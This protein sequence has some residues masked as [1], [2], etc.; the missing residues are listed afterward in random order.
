[1]R[2]KDQFVTGRHAKLAPEGRCRQSQ[3]LF[4]KNRGQ[5]SEELWCRRQEHDL[6][7]VALTEEHDRLV[8]VLR[9]KEEK[10]RAGLRGR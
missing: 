3:A 6:S 7:V 4:A 1:M 2:N 10:E 9:L 8:A 5:I